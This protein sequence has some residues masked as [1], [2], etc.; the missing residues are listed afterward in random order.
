MFGWQRETDREGRRGRVEMGVA[1]VV[2]VGVIREPSLI[3]IFIK[4]KLIKKICLYKL[5]LKRRKSEATLEE[6]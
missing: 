2:G 3:S 1:G 4:V 5:M 6:S